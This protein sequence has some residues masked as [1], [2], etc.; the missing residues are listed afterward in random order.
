MLDQSVHRL[1]CPVSCY[2]AW[3]RERAKRYYLKD[4]KAIDGEF[5]IQKNINPDEIAAVVVN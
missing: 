1:K 2:T 4:L 5:L 3:D